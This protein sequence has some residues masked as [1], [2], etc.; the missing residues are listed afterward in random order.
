MGT[1]S[2][3]RNTTTLGRALSSRRRAAAGLCYSWALPGGNT[4]RIDP[5]RMERTQCLYE[6]EVEYN[7]SE[8][9]VLPLRVEDL[10]EGSPEPGWLLK[11]R[12]KYPPSRGSDTLRD[13][14]ALF[15]G[16][17]AMRAHVMVTNGGA[18]ADYHA[19]L[20]PLRP[21]A[22]GAELSG[23]TT[24]TFWGRHDRVLV[25]GSLSK[26]FGLPGLRTGWIVGP[27]KTVERLCSYHDYLTLTPTYLSN[28]FAEIVMEPSRREAILERTR[29]IL[30]A[31]LPRLERWLGAHGDV[32]DCIRPL[33]GAIALLRYDLPIGSV[34]LLDRLRRAH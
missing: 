14:V 18:G 12:L 25:T 22:R 1:L 5:F 31:N 2:I 6:N 13:R 26:A 23:A 10:L 33:A 4:M 15:C 8:S 29:G 19:L 16:A 11:A 27:P 3:A 24:A 7:L 17:G 28:R 9:G 21:A 20:V 32:L 30:R 34:A